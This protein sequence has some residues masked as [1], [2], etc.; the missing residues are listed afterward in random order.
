MIKDFRAAILNLRSKSALLLYLTTFNRL[1]TDFGSCIKLNDDHELKQTQ[2]IGFRHRG[3]RL[4][5]TKK[6]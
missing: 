5:N 4:K 2:K 3:K 6:K 1:Q